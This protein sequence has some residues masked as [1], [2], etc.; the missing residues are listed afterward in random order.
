MKNQEMKNQKKLFVNNL[1]TLQFNQSTF[2]EKFL[3][4]ALIWCALVL[5]LLMT[6]SARAGYLY[7]L[8]DSVSGN[9][10]YGYSVNETNGALTPIPGSPFVTGG[11]SFSDNFYYEEQLTIDRL[12]NRLYVINDGSDT[13]SAY[14]IN[15]ANGALTPL[16]FSPI[17]LPAGQYGTIAVHPSGSPL[18]IGKS[19]VSFPF[20]PSSYSF[21]ITPTTAVAAQG[22]PFSTGAV[23]PGSSVFSQDGAYFYTGSSFGTE[24]AGFS[25]NQATGVLTPLP[26]SPFSYGASNA[27]G[28]ATD[29]QNRLFMTNFTADTLR[30]YQTTNGVPALAVNSPSASGLAGAADAVLHP[31][32]NFYVA[33]GSFGNHVGSFQIAGSGTATTLTPIAGSPFATGGL[34]SNTLV[35]NESGTFLF[36]ANGDSRNITTFNFDSLTGGLIFNNIQP[37]NTLG[38]TGRLAGIDYLPVNVVV[39]GDSDGDGV[40]DEVDNCPMT[41]NP[42]Q[43]DFDGDGIGDVCDAQTGPPTSKE[44]CKNGGWMIF[45]FP[46]IFQNQGDCIQFVNTGK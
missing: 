23:Y 44:Q 37:M 42:D 43:T 18:I 46:R 45:N 2:V 12:N 8:N 20:N 26:G 25:V 3:Q 36:V 17:A 4:S 38:A 15:P 14:S 6:T 24:F 21:V 34:W 11:T 32:G 27:G 1:A 30:A 10:I 13:V 5:V 22:S 16:P 35:F 31:S 28:F 39:G 7:A 41:T 29:A 40:S 33:V 9:T 19:N